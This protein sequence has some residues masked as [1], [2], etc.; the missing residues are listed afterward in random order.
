MHNALLK[1]D[2]A[3]LEVLAIDVM[4]RSKASALPRLLCKMLEREVWN[5]NT[6]DESGATIDKLAF[7]WGLLISYYIIA[8]HSAVGERVGL[9]LHQSPTA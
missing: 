6:N 5:C 1:L 2:A 3:R 8:A 4:A 7:V 9:P